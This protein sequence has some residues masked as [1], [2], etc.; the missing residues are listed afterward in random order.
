MQS[1]RAILA[2]SFEQTRN[3]SGECWQTGFRI[4]FAGQ[5]G[6]DDGGL[7][8]A[9]VGEISFALWGDELFFDEWQGGS[10]FKPDDAAH[11]VLDGVPVS[12]VELYRWTGRFVAYTLYQLCVMDCRLVSWVFR[13]LQRLADED[14]E[15]Q[16]DAALL[17]DL[18]SL[19]HVLA[20]N[21]W[22]VRH[23]LNEAELRWL[24]FT[25]PTGEELLP[26]GAAVEVSSG[27]V[28]EYLQLSCR[29]QLRRSQRGLAAFAEGFLEVVPGE[30]LRG[31]PTEGVLRL[32]LGSAEIGDAELDEL[33]RL[34]VPDG[35]VPLRLADHHRVRDTAR[36]LFRAARA[37]DGC[38]RARLLEFWMGTR[39]VPLAG[40]QA[41]HPRPKL[42]VMVQP[43][44]AGGVKRIAAWPRERLPEGHTCGNELWMALPDSYEEAAAKLRLA[45]ENFESGFALR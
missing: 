42:Q 22:R 7:T 4:N 6:L 35:L 1:A 14:T 3:L 11:V 41:V 28:A 23:E 25:L 39:R 19:D 45:V 31:L 34:V 17:A 8:K 13:S 12:S 9:W 2:F 38:F 30:A 26:G 10:F 32:L 44:A 37:G 40:L 16:D 33:E 24:D 21:L 5:Q 20:S 27:N 18:A 15:Q 43:D 36:W 29:A